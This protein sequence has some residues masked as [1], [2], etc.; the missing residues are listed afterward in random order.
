VIT[1][2]TIQRQVGGSLS[3]LFDMV[4]E[5][6][7]QRQQ[8]MRKVRSLTA[9]GRLSAYA[10]VGL[11]VFMGG[12]I[13]LLNPSYMAPLFTTSAG[14]LLIGLGLGMLATGSFILKRMVSF[15]G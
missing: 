1:A 2:V 13:T 12:T 6:V 8:F 5:T 14:H 7:R 3:G 4:A 15:R 11:P 9:M 10:L